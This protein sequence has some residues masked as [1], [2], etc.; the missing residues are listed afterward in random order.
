MSMTYDVAKNL[1]ANGFKKTGY[2]FDGWNTNSSGT[3]TNYTDKQSVK[4]LTSTNGGTVTL[5]A[6][7]KPITYTIKFDGN[8]A[9]GGSTAS[10]SM[11]YD[12]AKNLTANG[13]TK[14]GYHFSGWNTKADGSGTSYYNKQS[15]KNL[16]AT[17]GATITLYAPTF[18]F[19]RIL[20]SKSSRG[21][22]N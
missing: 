10:M 3:G 18:C 2:I 17:H 14:S 19:E 6:K 15:V 4:N 12:V 20:V 22:G 21:D 5:Y 1:T 16:T 8:G 9:T 13:F 11:T 7:W